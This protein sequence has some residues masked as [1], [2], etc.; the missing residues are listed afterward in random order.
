MISDENDST[1]QSIHLAERL[2][3]NQAAANEAIS[4]DNGTLMIEFFLI[5]N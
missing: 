5:R 4:N 2:S 1:A 3:A